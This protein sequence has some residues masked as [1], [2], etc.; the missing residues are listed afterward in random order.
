LWG[1]GPA[2]PDATSKEDNDGW[3]GTSKPK[4]AKKAQAEK[5]ADVDDAEWREFQM[6]R[7]RKAKGEI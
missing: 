7:M 4:A 1:K 6:Y 5:P 3:G 2:D